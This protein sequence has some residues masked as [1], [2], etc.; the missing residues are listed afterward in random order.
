MT[1]VLIALGGNLGDVRA[2][3]RTALD[4]L[5]A[6]AGV[7]VTAAGRAYRTPA[8]GA[9]A[10][11]AFLNAAATLETTL[12]PRA[13]LDE[14]HR[15]EAAAGRTRGVRWGPRPL[16]L[17][18]ILYGD[19]RIADDRLTVPHPALPWRRFVLDPACE[20]AAEWPVPGGGTVAGLRTALLARPLP[21][22]VRTGDAAFLRALKAGL[23]PAFPVR[24]G[25]EDMNESP[26]LEIAPGGGTAGDPRVV[27]V[28]ADADGAIRTLRDIFAAALPNPEPVAGG[29]AVWEPS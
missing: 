27:P 21:V 28:P 5:H 29:R 2:A 26:A 18:L 6:T 14:L 24:I 20:V 19:R 22:A 8:V 17:D 9:D 10:G 7:R 12:P 3:F 25:R 15:L 11:G 4:E 16:D 1:P 23:E 13:L